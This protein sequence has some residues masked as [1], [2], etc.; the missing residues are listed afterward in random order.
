MGKLNPLI[1]GNLVAKV[2]II[3]GGM[4][5]GI[6]LSGLAGA[7]AKNGGIGVISAAQPGYREEDFA[8]APLA[9]NLRALARE[10]RR[11]KEISDNGII[12][13]N[14]M[15]A[16]N[17]YERYVQCCIDS[18]ADLIISGAGLPTELPKLVE[19][20]DIKI[21]PIVSPPKAAKTLL[22]LWDKRYGK[23]ADLVVIEGALAGGHLGFDEAQIEK[24][25]EAGYDAEIREIIE[26][27]RE[28]EEKYDKKIPVVFGGGVFDRQ[29]IDRY[30]ALG[31]S[32]VQMGTRFVATEECDADIR[33]KQAYIKA[34]EE[35]IIVKKSPVGMP[36]RAI[37]NRLIRE[38]EIEKK[39]ITHCYGCLQQCDRT[40]IPYCITTALIAAAEGRVD[41]ALL[42]CGENAKRITEIT[43]VEK[44]MKELSE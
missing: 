38:I 1:I 3:Q 21:A 23:T 2:P 37:K 19:G 15:C 42:F 35:D 39:K 34:K 36:G 32:G 33:F 7:V 12:G 20:S 18:G 11:A 14:I 27:V 29:D 44:L 24:V 40:S 13:V 17:H 8:K 26:I 43:T 30:L 4:G 6:S 22:R 10:I 25:K 28:Y 16:A 5:I 31:C 9:A 41:D